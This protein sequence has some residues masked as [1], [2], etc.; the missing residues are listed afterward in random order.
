MI[1][2]TEIFPNVPKYVNHL[3]VIIKLCSYI[4]CRK[5]RAGTH[6]QKKNLT[7]LEQAI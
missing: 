2:N 3:N 6:T 7:T 1:L 5:Q 4:K